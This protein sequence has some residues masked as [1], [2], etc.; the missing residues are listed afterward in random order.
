V[1]CQY[2][3]KSR[4]RRNGNVSVTF[5]GAPTNGWLPW[6]LR[7]WQNGEFVNGFDE[8]LGRVL[9]R[10]LRNRRDDPCGNSAHPVGCVAGLVGINT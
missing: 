9:R 8:R 3:L 6:N 7:P 5:T 4:P 10:T 1:P 2:A